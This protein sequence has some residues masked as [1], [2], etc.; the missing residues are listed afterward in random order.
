MDPVTVGPEAF[1]KEAESEISRYRVQAD[2]A[3]ISLD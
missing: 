3:G 2:R 1:R